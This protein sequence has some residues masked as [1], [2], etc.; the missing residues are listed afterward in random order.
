LRLAIYD[1]EGAIDPIRLRLVN[2]GDHITVQAVDR[3][4]EC[5]LS[6]NILSFY[7]NGTMRRH[8]SLNPAIGFQMDNTKI[9]EDA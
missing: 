7:P 1:E 3:M 4:G 9:K 2:E 8:W 6:G 5:L